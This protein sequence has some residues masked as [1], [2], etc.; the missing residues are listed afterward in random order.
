M[1]GLANDHALSTTQRAFLATEDA[2][3]ESGSVAARHRRQC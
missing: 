1:M 2:R 3:T